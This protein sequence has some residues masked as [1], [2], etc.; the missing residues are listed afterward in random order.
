[1]QRFKYQL[2]IL[3]SLKKNFRTINNYDNLSICD[4]FLLK[5]LKKMPI[6]KTAGQN[7]SSLLKILKEK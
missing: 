3:G 5:L 7:S 4:Y 1:M 6:K 2:N